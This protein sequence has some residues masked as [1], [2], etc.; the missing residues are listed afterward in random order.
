[1]KIIMDEAMMKRSLVRIAHEIIE[2]NKG[3][4]DLV[5]VGIKTRGI[6]LAKRLKSI[7]ESFEVCNIPCGSIDIQPWRDDVREVI[8][9]M[10]LGIDV[11]DKIVILVDDVLFS[12]RTTRA[13]MDGVMH[14]GRAREIHLA[15]L[16]DRGH[17]Q[18]P[19]KADYVGKNVPTSKDEVVKVML[20][21]HDL[22]DKVVIL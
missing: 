16:V 4:Q 10:D 13:A 22:E 18:L 7:I 9:T 17:R 15:V 21:E 14:Y 20:L 19:I 6:Y 2:T 11:K 5:L 1:M 8:P 12:G 3:T